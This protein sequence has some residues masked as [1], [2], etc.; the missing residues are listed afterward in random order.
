ML[1]VPLSLL[2]VAAASGT[3]ACGGD[4]PLVGSWRSDARLGNGERNELTVAPDFTGEATLYATPAGAPTTWVQL[5]FDLEW[6]DEGREF[7]LDLDCQGDACNGDDLKMKCT[8]ISEAPGEADKMDCDGEGKWSAYPL[9]WE[10][11]A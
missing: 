1:A 2:V 4:P 3:T 11:D 9:D 8:I 7:D 5:E 10:R 6:A